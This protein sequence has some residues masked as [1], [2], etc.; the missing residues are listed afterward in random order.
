LDFEDIRPFKDSEYLEKISLLINEENFLE[1]I[2]VY[3]PELNN[4]DIKDRL[5][6]YTSIREF[7]RKMVCDVV[8]RIKDKSIDEFTLEGFE[9][10]DIHKNYLFISNHRDIVLDSALINYGLFHYLLE[11]SEIAIGSNLLSEDWIKNLVRLNKSFIVKRDIPKQELLPSSKQLSEYIKFT[12]REKKEN[13]WIAQK[14][15]RAKDGNDYTNPGLLKMLAMA[16]EENILDYLIS[17]SIVPISLSYQYDPCDL[18]KIPEQIAKHN[19]LTYTKFKG[20]DALHMATGIQGNKGNV[21][22]VVGKCINDELIKLKELKNRNELLKT[23]AHIIDKEIHNNYQLWDTNYVAYDLLNDID[24]Y[25]NC[26]SNFEKDEFKKYIQ[27]QINAFQDKKLAEKIILTMYAN[28]V[29]NKI[30]IV[31]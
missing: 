6:S 31:S 9:N 7:Q 11:T 5:L 14:E 26:Y 13:I 23:V 30:K 28:P 2:H 15:G 3:Y 21:K 12:L 8:E 29:I 19:N 27:Q 18:L 22:I 1:S 4:N 24:T 17:L 10:L 20:E 16:S 25:K